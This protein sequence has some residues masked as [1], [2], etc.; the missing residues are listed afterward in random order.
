[1]KKP[2]VGCPFDVGMPATEEAYNLGCLPSVSEVLRL[3][4]GNTSAWACHSAP[5]AVCA[6]FVEMRPHAGS[7]PL[8]AYGRRS[9]GAC[10]MTLLPTQ[11]PRNFGSRNECLS[12]LINRACRRVCNSAVADGIGRRDFRGEAGFAHPVLH[13]GKR[14]LYVANALHAAS[15]ADGYGPRKAVKSGHLWRNS[16][17]G[18]PRYATVFQ[19]ELQ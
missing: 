16:L 4:E 5:Q 19:G 3:C 17:S 12:G 14:S 7:L 1:M 18:Y 11:L 10:A 6:G 15:P 9:R 13:H 2:C 8:Q